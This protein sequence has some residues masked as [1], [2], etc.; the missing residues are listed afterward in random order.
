MLVRQTDVAGNVSTTG[1]LTFTLDASVPAAPVITSP[2]NGST[3]ATAT[4]TITGT[5][6]AGAVVTILIDSVVAGT[7]TVGGGGTWSFTPAALSNAAHT[8]TATETDPAGNVSTTSA[9]D[10]FTVNS[11]VP[12]V[13]VALVQDTG[14]SAADRITSNAALT[15]TSDPGAAITLTEN[16]T[17]IGTATA[18][19]SGVW[20]FT[21]SGLPAGA[22]TIVASETNGAG[23]TGSGSLTFTFD[24]S[25]PAAPVITSPP[26]GSTIA[27]TTPTITGTGEAGATVTIRIDGVVA[28]TATVGGS[29]TWSFTPSALSNAAHTITATGT[30]LAGNVSITSTNDRFTIN[31]SVPVVTVALVQDT[32]SSAADRITSNPMLTGTADPGATVVFTDNGAALA[33][34]SAN[35]SGVWTFSPFGLTAGAHTIIVR[36]TNAAG[37]AGSASLTFTLDASAP[38]LPL[39]ALATDSGSSGSDRI[40]NSGVVN[41]TGLEAGATWVYSTNGGA[42]FTTGTGTSFTTT[43]TGTKNVSVR[44]TDV[45]GNVSANGSLAFTLDTFVPVPPSLALATDSGSSRSDRITNSGVINVTG[46][47]GGAAWAYSTDNGATYTT[48]TGLSFTLAGDGAKNVLARQTDTAGNVSP[49]TAFAFTLDR[50]APAVA[51]TSTGG[52]AASPTVTVSGTGEAGTTV[53]LFNGSAAIGA[54]VTVGGGGTW[55]TAITLPASG[56]H[57]IVAKDTDLA[58]N[59]GISN[60][61]TYTSPLMINLGAQAVVSDTGQSAFDRIT[62]DGRVK[63][64][65]TIEGGTGAVG[66]HVFNG[67]TDLGAATVTGGNWTFATTLAE[68]TFRLTAVATDSANQTRTTPSAPVIVVDKTAPVVSLTSAILE[69]A[70]VFI[71]ASGT[72]EDYPF[73][74]VGLF[75]G[76]G[77]Y[78]YGADARI[79]DGHWNGSAVGGRGSS[80]M[81]RGLLT[82]RQTDIAGNTGISGGPP[83]AITEAGFYVGVPQVIAG[84]GQAGASIDV[85]LSSFADIKI[86]GTTTVGGDG[87]WSFTAPVA[88]DF[89]PPIAADIFVTETAASGAKSYAYTVVNRSSGP[90]LTFTGEGTIHTG[91]AP[92][93]TG[94]GQPGA[95]VSTTIGGLP[96][97]ATVGTNGIWS[98]ALPTSFP[99]LL[100]ASRSYKGAEVVVTETSAAGG[101][102]SSL[103]VIFVQSPSGSAQTQFTYQSALTSG[104]FAGRIVFGSYLEGSTVYID[105]NNNGLLDPGEA[106]AVTDEFGR[107][108]LPG[109]GPLVVFGGTNTA[110]GLPFKGQFTAPD[111][112]RAVSAL[113]TLSEILTA[114]GSTT[115]NQT[116]LAAFGLFPGLN[117]ETLNPIAARRPV[118]PTPPKPSCRQQRSTT[119]SR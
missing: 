73:A 93:I 2:A 9:S 104:Y 10:T 81:L 49:T 61:V 50:A 57:T 107:Y 101:I 26:D 6:E 118:T 19:G 45:A 46:Q 44:Q 53:Q 37:T 111:G 87:K 99:T 48:G 30:D 29:N 14:S 47:E 40:T 39:L 24:A 51:I 23:T 41:V 114:R 69:N 65:G 5:G 97:T 106:S 7:A 98:L 103:V 36:E 85:Q 113:T 110:T 72:G 108:D 27:T 88:A 83:L 58:G 3:I 70:R 100:P 71:R 115:A 109:S 66:V 74:G 105:T 1:A 63:L 4:P 55:S 54:P 8:I 60:G 102:T 112:S 64:F 84:T 38:A 62:N 28:G 59:I 31:T 15:G 68:G 21:P 43:G 25:A 79:V 13:T 80:F 89:F 32:G 82:A 34:V 117:L 18:N 22:H 96:V 56:N 35:G 17:T 116:V 95:T 67:S 52:A 42:T 11:T 91:N 76:D 90:A 12:V 92:A 78:T 16:G 33:S 75:I 94:T 20:S 119:R 77:N 86:F